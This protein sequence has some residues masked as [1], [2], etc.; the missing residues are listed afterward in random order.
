M[1]KRIG[2]RRK[3]RF[4]MKKSVRERGKI[5]FTRFFA[6]YKAGDKVALKPEPSYHKGCYFKRFFGK[7]AEITGKRGRCYIVSVNDQGKMKR[8]IVHPVHMIRKR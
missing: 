3:T 8:L 1:V 5:S 7:T 6:E 4:K 2:N